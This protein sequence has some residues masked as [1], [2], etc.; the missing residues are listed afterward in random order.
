[1]AKSFIIALTGASGAAYG[2]RLTRE[3][4]NAGHSVDMITSSTARLII[5]DEVGLDLAGVEAQA[6]AKIAD[7]LGC[8]ADDTVARLSVY[9]SEL[10]SAP[11]ASGSALKRTMVICPCSMGTLGRIAS[12]VSINLIDRSADCILKER[13]ELIVVPRETPLNAIHLENM[14]KLSKAGATIAPAM[15]AFYNSPQSTDDMVDFMVGKI[16]DLL[17]VSNTLYKRW[18]GDKV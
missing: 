16:L 7:F 3:L 1:V 14:L 12:G 4:L 15:P 13:G 11:L 10:I 17:G 18:Q 9:P 8:P 6:A 5:K 2:L